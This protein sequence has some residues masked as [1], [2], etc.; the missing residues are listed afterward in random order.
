MIRN[1]AHDDE[2][3]VSNYDRTLL[4]PLI[5]MGKHQHEETLREGWINILRDLVRERGLDWEVYCESHPL[6]TDRN[7]RRGKPTTATS[8]KLAQKLGIT[9]SELLEELGPTLVTN[10]EVMQNP[11]ELARCAERGNK[12]ALQKLLRLSERDDSEALCLLGV[13]YARGRGVGK[14]VEKAESLY[15]RAAALGNAKAKRELG[16]IF[17]NEDATT[18]VG[19]YLKA[20]IMGDSQAQFKLGWMYLRD[21]GVSK[22]GPEERLGIAVN[23][24][25]KAAAQGYPNALNQ[26]GF[27]YKTGKGVS[28]CLKKA[29]E[30]FRMAADQGNHRACSNFGVMC[31]NGEGVVKDLVMAAAYFL[32]ASEKGNADAQFHLS[33]MYESGEGMSKND[34]EAVRWLFESAKH[35]D[36]R[37]EH[38]LGERYAAGR[39]VNRDL[40]LGYRWLTRAAEHDDKTALTSRN[41]IE[42]RMTREQKAKAT[43]GS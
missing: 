42:K 26:L 5:Y 9:R 12:V 31:M 35:G 2:R 3:G 8:R 28:K 15:R 16:V 17:E 14:D 23:W 37:A 4:L 33:K 21:T 10:V 27:L 25:E 36:A 20:A 34:R 7:L 19:W 22:M 11:T 6:T 29:G 40:V 38:E 39:G 18:A 1:T 24:I 13:M 30:C 41:L 43:E 32:R